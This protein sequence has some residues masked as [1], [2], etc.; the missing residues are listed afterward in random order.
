M[1]SVVPRSGVKDG[2]PTRRDVVVKAT[3]VVLKNDQVTSATE[4]IANTFNMEYAEK[5][6]TATKTSA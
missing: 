2:R 6:P 5:I 4:N 3:L 1:F